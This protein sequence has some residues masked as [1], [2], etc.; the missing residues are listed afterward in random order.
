MT[1]TLRRLLATLTPK[2][3][4]PVVVRRGDAGLQRRDPVIGVDQYTQERRARL[5]QKATKS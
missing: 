3:H 2:L 4:S 5:R 1:P